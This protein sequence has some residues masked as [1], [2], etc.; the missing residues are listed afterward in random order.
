MSVATQIRPVAWRGAP[1][2]WL[3]IVAAAALLLVVFYDGLK[4]MV[5]SWSGRQ[6]YGHGF[7]LPFV[8][9]FLVWQ[10]KHRL[11]ALRFEGSWTGLLIVLAG[12]ALYFA[13]ELSTLY[14]VVQY[15]FLV[16]LVGLILALMGW[17][18]FKIVW[19]PLLILFFMVPLP[20][21]LYQGLSGELQLVS[22]QLGVSVIRLCDISVFL[23]GNVI[24]LGNYKLQVAEACSGLRYLF[25]LMALGFIAA[26][27]FNGALWKRAVIFLSTIPITIL[28]NSFRIGMIG[29]LVE[30]RGVS[31]AEGFLHDFEGWA[32][33]MACTAVLVAEMWVLA[34]IGKERRSLGQVFRLDFPAPTAPGA[35][36]RYRPIPKPFLAGV[37]V[38]AVVATLSFALPQRVEASVQ[39]N[40]FYEFPLKLD[41]WSGTSGRLAPV[42]LDVLKLDDYI[43]ADFVGIDRRPVNFYVAYYASQRKGESAHS[44][45]SCIPG[46]GWEITDLKQRYV[47][48]VRAAGQPLRVNRVLIQRGES[49]QLVY[50]WFQQRGRIITNEYLVKWYLFWD[51]LTRNRTDGALVR[52]VTYV[53]PGQSVEQADRE[54]IAFA[55][56]VSGPLEKYIPD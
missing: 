10:K 22:S 19:V 4:V 24:D 51:A 34:K 40:S 54:L 11:E 56:S 46:G 32:I 25:P 45:R 31:M 37:L 7:A 35:Q 2:L 38:L 53:G 1:W 47:D 9:A 41:G 48:G 12:I 18:A 33:F 14:V 39:R 16:V 28:M 44:P 23:E 8:A 27:L 49:K 13:G 42:E 30:Y 36:L 5:E 3:L 20:N 17:P 6:E 55:A 21:F 15:S 52:L 50:Y 43:L 26:Y 29:V